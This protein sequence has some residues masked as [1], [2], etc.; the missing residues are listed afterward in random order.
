[1]GFNIKYFSTLKKEGGVSL[2]AEKILKLPE[3]FDFSHE[4]PPTGYYR[5]GG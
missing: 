2:L 1:L 5:F 4:N 3:V